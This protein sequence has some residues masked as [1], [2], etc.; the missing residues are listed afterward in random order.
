MC[1]TMTN[2]S[3]RG[4]NIRHPYPAWLPCSP[5]TSR[6][7]LNFTAMAGSTKSSTAKSSACVSSTRRADKAR[8]PPEPS[9][10]PEEPTAPSSDEGEPVSP[11]KGRQPGAANYSE[12]DV[13]HL[14][15][16]VR[17][18]LPTGTTAW[19]ALSDMYNETIEGPKRGPEALEK[20]FR[21]VSLD[22]IL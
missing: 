19:K 1:V 21:S 20:K 13:Q 12:D 8:A 22:L 14:V 4:T 7:P 6:S 5:T 15:D 9:P 16:C 17:E 2:R 3:D 11:A 10:A 18:I